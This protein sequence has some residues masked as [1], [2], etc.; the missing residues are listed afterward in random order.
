MN[1]PFPRASKLPTMANMTPRSVTPFPNMFGST[2]AS[3]SDNK[4][5]EPCKME[6]DKTEQQASNPFDQPMTDA[7]DK[8]NKLEM[9]DVFDKS[10]QPD[11][12]NQPAQPAAPPTRPALKREFTP[13]HRIKIWSIKAWQVERRFSE[14]FDDIRKTLNQVCRLYPS[15]SA[16]LNR[17]G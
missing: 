1:Q 8:S 11:Q 4:A 17:S 6:I 13:P 7:P 15:R 12:L 5:D 2:M 14:L 10:D 3:S 16:R 9:P